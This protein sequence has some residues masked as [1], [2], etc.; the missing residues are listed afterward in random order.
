MRAR[1]RDNT[2]G[3]KRCPARSAFTLAEVLCVIIIVGIL[4]AIV[5]PQLAPAD[6]LSTSAAA[7]VMIG[8]LLY[9]QDLAIATRSMTFVSFTV[10]GA[11][12]SGGYNLYGQQPFGSPLTNPVT[13]Q[14][15]TV[16]F[17]SGS[18]TQLAGVQLASV[19]FD[20]PINT[21]L[22]FD[23]LGQPYACTTSGVPVALANSGTITLQCG[24]QTLT[25][26][27]EP[28]TGNITLP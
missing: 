8:D 22:A 15:Y 27:I 1:T 17:G 20:G 25:M 9:A 14:P 4:A 5:M 21:A 11:G 24:S 6:D 18:A 16:A 10:A 2:M 28:D 13:H 23:A 3:S 12:G 7:R 26:S 19:N